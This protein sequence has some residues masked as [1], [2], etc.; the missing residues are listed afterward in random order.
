MESSTPPTEAETESFRFAVELE[1]VQCLG[2]VRYLTHLAQNGYFKK[3]EFVNYLK[4]LLYWKDPKYAKYVKF[5][6]CLHLLDLLQHESFRDELINP[7][8]SKYIDDQILL[9]WQHYTRRRI[10]LHKSLQEQLLA[11][12]QATSNPGSSGLSSQSVANGS[13]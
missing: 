4:Y 6:I 2:N 12:Q 9:H 7:Q 13:N 11:R 1:F 5:P 10:Q 3:P 8:C